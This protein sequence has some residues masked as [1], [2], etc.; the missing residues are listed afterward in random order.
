VALDFIEMS[1]G[2][3]FDAATTAADEVMVGLRVGRQFKEAPTLAEVGFA[4]Y[5]DRDE[6]LQG[7]VHRRKIYL[8]MP[9]NDFGMDLFGG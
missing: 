1:P 3:V 2:D 4:N 6:H 5:F 8:R 9:P 7:P